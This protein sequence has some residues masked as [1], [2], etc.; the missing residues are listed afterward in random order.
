[1]KVKLFISGYLRYF[2]VHSSYKTVICASGA[3][4]L[5]W[6]NYFQIEYISIILNAYPLRYEKSL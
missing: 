6:R 3:S 2:P 5:H 4:R 1:M